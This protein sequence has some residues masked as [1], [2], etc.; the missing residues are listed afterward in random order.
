ML[1]EIQTWALAFEG[2]PHLSYVKTIYNKLKSEGAQFPEAGPV[3][4]SFVDSSAVIPLTHL[5]TDVV[6]PPEWADS[7]RCTRCH[8]QFTLTNRKHHCR[9]CGNVYCGDCSSKTMPLPHLGIAQPVRV[10]DTCYDE[11]NSPKNVKSLNIA[12]ASSPT[13]QS[14]RSMHPR[15]A[16]VEDDD[17]KDLKL[18]LQ[19]SLE[20]A[21]RSGID[22]QPAAPKSEPV[23]PVAQP[24]VTRNT[25]EVE[26]ED[27]KAAIAASLK[28]ME[29]KKAMQYPPV[30]PISSQQSQPTTNPPPSTQYPQ[31]YYSP[32][33]HC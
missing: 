32:H 29:S 21:K 9:N 1:E 10:C 2:R 28:D 14:S 20:E 8:N 17:D 30:Q 26:D 3:S 16:R 18:A 7:D 31:V 27:L 19:M 24:T 13:T 12:P 15:S 33:R 11:R 23:K 5:K 25:Q 4:A 6:Q 22:P